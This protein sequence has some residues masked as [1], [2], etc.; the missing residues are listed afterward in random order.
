MPSSL[1]PNIHHR[2]AVWIALAIALLLLIPALRA[3][4]LDAL[5]RALPA[6]LMA[7]LWAIA[8]TGIGWFVLR[9][10]GM[11]GE[12]RSLADYLL[13]GSLPS[14][15]LLWIAGLLGLLH[16]GLAYAI[17]AFGAL[18]AW[19]FIRAT[20]AKKPNDNDYFERPDLML[21]VFLIGAIGA[22]LI[23]AAYSTLPPTVY[24]SMVNH[25]ALIE[26]YRLSGRISVFDHHLMSAYPKFGDM[27]LMGPLMLGGPEA[28]NAFTGLLAF[29]T[30]SQAA[31]LGRELAGKHSAGLITASLLLATPLFIY[32]ASDVKN[33]LALG[34]FE[35][36]AVAFLLLARDDRREL[37][38]AGLAL[39]LAIATKYSALA[40]APGLLMAGL[41]L[42][43]AVSARVR[44][45][46]LAKAGVIGALVAVP[47]YLET[48]IATGSPLYPTFPAI[49]G[50]VSGIDYAAINREIQHVASLN[51][52]ATFVYRLF[53]D[54]FSID[55]DHAVLGFSWLLLLP[56]ALLVRQSRDKRRLALLVLLA[57][58]LIPLLLITT[59][60]RF[61]PMVY[62]LPPILIGARLSQLK[63]TIPRLAT[64]GVAIIGLTH[65]LGLSLM[66]GQ[67]FFPGVGGLMSGELKR[68]DYLAQNLPPYAAFRQIEANTAAE[69]R[70]LVEG[71][72]RF[73][74]L[75][76]RVYQPVSP[77]E[78]GVL[79]AF[80]ASGVSGLEAARRLLA[81]GVRVVYLGRAEIKRLGKPELPLEFLN[82]LK[83][84]CP[85]ASTDTRAEIL[86]CALP[87]TA[88]P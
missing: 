43:G 27:L 19:P 5:T 36:S 15:L 16:D 23:L 46:T 63:G 76:R 10:L 42:R 58:H 71:E 85:V 25:L 62:L 9:L 30:V 39:G 33:D 83:S 12:R 77:Y 40:F 28:A 21:W 7:G 8:L 13:V 79:E 22:G 41:I 72:R 59:K 57:W 55:G 60:L 38:L 84:L 67:I 69:D 68:D 37:L 80:A 52:A 82:D 32:L 70:V 4:P 11:S 18:A 17:T 87:K 1:A 64:S 44:L 45:I 3:F 51:D 75:A 29:A 24:D 49:F 54:P 20:L 81:D 56:F 53:F 35:L 66:L 78:P 61:Y 73:A 6:V 31:R 14:V 48:W 50:T 86:I 26:Q 74:Y 88:S 65:A 2:V 47:F 34:F